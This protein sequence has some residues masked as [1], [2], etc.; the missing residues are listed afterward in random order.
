MMTKVLCDPIG[1]HNPNRSK[2]SI[3]YCGITVRCAKDVQKHLRILYMAS[4]ARLYQMFC[5]NS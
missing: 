2:K 1:H 5:G 3:W 4:I